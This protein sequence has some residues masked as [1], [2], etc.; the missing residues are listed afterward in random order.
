MGFVRALSTQSSQTNQFRD[1]RSERK[2]G[3][4]LRN[5]MYA[6]IVAC[7]AGASMIVPAIPVSAAPQVTRQVNRGADIVLVKGELNGKL[8]S[9]NGKPVDGAVV[10]VAKNGKTIAKTATKTDGSYTVPG[11]STGAHTIRMADG[12]FPVRLWSE[13]AAPANAQSSLVVAKTAVRGQY[14][15]LGISGTQ[16]LIM[17][18]LLGAGIA[19]GFAIGDSQNNDD[20]PPAKRDNLPPVSP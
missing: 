1:R 9:A 20:N 16:L 7:A 3:H 6:R 4:M 5:S 8:L 14:S 13:Q 12:E 11:L 19:A 17:G 2:Y 10:S 15:L 18:G